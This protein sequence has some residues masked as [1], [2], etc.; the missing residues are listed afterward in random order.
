[1][2]DAESARLRDLRARIYA[3][4]ELP[5]QLFALYQALE[6]RASAGNIIPPHAYLIIPLLF[7]ETN[8][9]AS[10]IYL[11]SDSLSHCHRRSRYVV[12]F[13]CFL[14]IVT[15]PLFI[16]LYLF[17]FSRLSKTF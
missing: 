5:P 4:E 13:V 9:I 3:G 15:K 8:T 17:S 14:Y 16:Y 11:F 6:A 7:N 1:M 12:L 10:I 2:D